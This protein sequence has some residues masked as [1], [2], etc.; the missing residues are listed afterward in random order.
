MARRLRV[1]NNMISVRFIHATLNMHGALFSTARLC[2]AFWSTAHFPSISIELAIGSYFAQ[3]V[4]CTKPVPRKAEYCVPVSLTTTTTATNTP[5]WFRAIHSNMQMTDSLERTVATV[6]FFLLTE[7]SPQ[8]M[9]QTR[10]R[11]HFA[12]STDKRATTTKFK[13]T[14]HSFGMTAVQRKIV[15]KSYTSCV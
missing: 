5:F 1:A 10:E 7:P 15:L 12:R 13:G 8:P 11:M 9:R 6:S 3:P 2:N 14:E 4:K